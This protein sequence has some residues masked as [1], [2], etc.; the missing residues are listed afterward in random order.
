M[1]WTFR[2]IGGATVENV[3]CL[4]PAPLIQAQ[5]VSSDYFTDMVHGYE[6]KY[7]MDWLT[8]YTEHQHSQEELNE[9][10]SD[11]LFL[12][13]AYFGDLVAA[14]GPPKERC[15]HKPDSKSGFC[16]L[17]D[18]ISPPC[19]TIPSITLNSL[20]RYLAPVSMSFPI[21]YSLNL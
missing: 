17:R 10:F 21:S 6:E 8:F 2:E 20:T 15:S 14:N 5:S 11:W 9:D 12:C 4:C 13:K 3:K 19:K 7:Q 18:K 1:E 16:Y